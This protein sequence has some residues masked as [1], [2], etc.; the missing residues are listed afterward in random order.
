MRQSLMLKERLLYSEDIQL[1]T[2]VSYSL[3][4]NQVQTGSFSNFKH[5]VNKTNLV[6]ECRV[7]EKL[8]RWSIHGVELLNYRAH[9]VH[10]REIVAFRKHW[11][12]VERMKKLKQVRAQR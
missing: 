5:P 8:W 2:P 4:Q 6:H 7:V 11:S 1:E 12:S 3:D 10:W 9:T